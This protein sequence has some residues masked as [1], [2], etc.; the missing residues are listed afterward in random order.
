MLRFRYFLEFLNSQQKNLFI[1]AA[2]SNTKLG[3]SCLFFPPT[4]L[5]SD[6][7]KK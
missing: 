6:F 7:L 3:L 1:K 2:Y 4:L 5:A